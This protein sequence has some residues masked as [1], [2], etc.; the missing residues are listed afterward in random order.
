MP[1]Y[2]HYRYHDRKNRADRHRSF[3]KQ[4]ESH[5]CSYVKKDNT[6]C[7]RM[8]IIGFEYCSSHR[9]IAKKVDIKDSAIAGK[10]LF[11]SNNKDGNQPEVI[12]RK[13]ER[14]GTYDGKKITKQQLEEL[15]GDGTAPY[16]LQVGRD[17]IDAAT[18]RSTMSLVNHSNQRGANAK[19]T[20]A[21]NVVAL[22][23]IRDG[24]EIM[25]NYGREYHFNDSTH[26]TNKKKHSLR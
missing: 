5:R 9:E 8:S 2:F 22:K 13:G 23:N 26:V 10:G 15:Y 21:G 6:R 4:L 24:N 19:F 14:I 3:D 17:Y 20:S 25:V 18:K 11:A 16:T 1:T 12:F 7:K